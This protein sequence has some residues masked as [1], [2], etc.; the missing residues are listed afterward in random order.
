MSAAGD[1]LDAALLRALREGDLDTA[2]SLVERRGAALAGLDP[3]DAETLARARAS[4]REILALAGER[5]SAVR[6]EL[7]A[8]LAMRG[9]L[10]RRPRPRRGARYIDRRA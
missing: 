6:D 8:L 5:R 1:D 3:D 2:E 10:A 7:D 9:R 4:D